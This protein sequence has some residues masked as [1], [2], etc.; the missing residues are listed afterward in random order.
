VPAAKEF[1]S[2]AFGLPVHR[3][4]ADSAVFKFGDTHVNLLRASQSA[5]AGRVVSV[6][7]ASS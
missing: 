2:A 6:T 4:D 5:W 3:E 1:Y 7:L